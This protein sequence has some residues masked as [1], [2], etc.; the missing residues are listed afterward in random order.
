[1]RGFRYSPPPF[2][3]TPELSWVLL[4][5]FAPA[6]TEAPAGFDPEAA[7]T[8]AV[9]LDLAARIGAR[10]RA[11][12]LEWEAGSQVAARFVEAYHTTAASNVQLLAVAREIQALAVEHGFEV[13]FL[14]STALL[15][16]GITA[17][18][19]RNAVDIDVLVNLK[20]LGRLRGYLTAR[21]YS[22]GSDGRKDHQLMPMYHP[23]GV[24][25]EIH[26]SVKGLYGDGARWVRAEG[27]SLDS[28]RPSGSP[29]AQRRLVPHGPFLA[30]HAMVHAIVQHGAHPDTY[31]NLRLIADLADLSQR[32]I[33]SPFLGEILSLACGSVRRDEAESVLALTQALIEAT[34]RRLGEL[35]GD[36]VT[37]WWLR[38]AL[39]S[40]S[41]DS[42]REY[43]RV[44]GIVWDEVD[45]PRGLVLVR[46]VWRALTLSR[47]EMEK[48]Y[49]SLDNPVKRFFV[50]VWRPCDLIVRTSRYALRHSKYLRKRDSDRGGHH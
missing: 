10:N 7:W 5:A 25:V 48:R 2:E 37:S 47:A 46:K 13:V 3:L 31:P 35:A 6:D 36:A 40:I 8:V 14:K 15:Q 12:C 44:P 32:N 1:M 24:M 38:H 18:G 20:H 17:L 11:D 30:A 41:D 23:A 45:A 42:Y 21:G 27:L 19:A 26:K 4:R 16:S 50:R 49:G 34:P 9:E 43:L 29:S 28:N 33:L 22:G 39:G